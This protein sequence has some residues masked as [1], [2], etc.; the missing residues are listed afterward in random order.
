[1]SRSQSTNQAFPPI[2]PFHAAE[3]PVSDGSKLYFEQ[4]GNPSGQPALYLHGGPGGSCG[5]GTRR[6]F[7]PEKYHAVLFDQRG[8]GRSKPLASEP[9][10]DFSNN[11]TAQQIDDIESLR[12]HLGIERWVLVAGS[13]GVTLALAYAQAFPQRV[14]AMVLGS[15]T[16]GTRQEID[17]ITRDMG[18]IFPRE[19]QSFV[20]YLPEEQRECSYTEDDTGDICAAY[21]KLLQSSDPAVHQPAAKAWCKWEDTHVSLMPGWQPSARFQDPEL[22]LIFARLVTHYWSNDCFL[23]PNQLIQNI[24]KIADI[25]A[26]LIHGKWDISGP[27][28]TAYQLHNVWPASE[29]CILEEAGHGGIGFGQAIRQAL[30]K[31]A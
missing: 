7:D 20:E 19:W 16:L 13:W 23:A 24:E 9:D 15:V 8:C 12:R 25:P 27:L 22:S 17:W 3:L 29:L 6:Y 14:K 11:N 10:Y 21:A 26:V 4:V 18:R 1:M 31:F 28:D 2:E 5:P 30:A